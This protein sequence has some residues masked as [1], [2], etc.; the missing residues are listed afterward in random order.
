MITRW[1]KFGPILDRVKC[2]WTL[3]VNRRT[4][5]G[6]WLFTPVENSWKF[7]L[8]ILISDDA[9]GPET[10]LILFV[11][12]KF[13]FLF[14]DMEDA[15]LK[16]IFSPFGEIINLHLARDEIS[17]CNK[18]LNKKFRCC[19]I[20]RNVSNVRNFSFSKFFNYLG[21]RN[22]LCQ[23]DFHRKKVYNTSCRARRAFFE[24]EGPRSKNRLWAVWR[25]RKIWKIF[26][27]KWII[28]LVELDELF[29]TIEVRDL[30]TAC[31]RCG[32]HAKFENNAK[33]FSDLPVTW[34]TFDQFWDMDSIDYTSKMCVSK[35]NRRFNCTC[36]QKMRFKF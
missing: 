19:M 2:S 20:F 4:N 36:Q 1:A 31:G 35:K 7:I 22:N 23:F 34:C 14:K 32:A 17:K 26:E 9:D 28:H 11:L 27:K 10:E 18:V 13:S 24:N 25:Q 5:P 12:T 16:E 21:A 15:D 33:C 6:F 30:K 29:P 8:D 3:P